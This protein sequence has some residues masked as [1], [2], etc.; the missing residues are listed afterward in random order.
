MN[1]LKTKISSII[2]LSV[3]ALNNV[4]MAQEYGK[5]YTGITPTGPTTVTSIVSLLGQIVKWV[6]I[7]FFII[8]V[9]FIILAAFAYLT[10]GG[11]E[12]KVKNAKNR[13]I[14][15]AVAIVVALLAVGFESIIRNF[16]MTGA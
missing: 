10:A 13:I 7:I 4:A 11:D 6:Y 8:A 1:S 15:A 16:L 3:L 12:E 14:Y 2:T 9:L 5:Q